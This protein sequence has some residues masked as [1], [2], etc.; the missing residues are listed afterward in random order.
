MG[1]SNQKNDNPGPIMDLSDHLD[2][3]RFRLILA[4][5][6]LVIAIIVCLF[7]GNTIIMLLQKP[8]FFVMGKESHLQSLSPAD[9]FI[10]YMNVSMITGIILASPWIFYQLWMFISVGLYLKEKYYVYITLPFAMLLFIAGSLFFIFI[11]APVTLRFL[12][13]FNRELLH[14]ESNFTFKNYL[15]FI[16]NMTLA[17]G[18]AF[19][20]PIVVF[21]LNKIGLISIEQLC[22]SRKVVLLG[23]V[24]IAAIITPG[25]DL[26]SLSSLAIPLYLLFEI[27]ILI[28][29]FANRKK[30]A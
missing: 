17:F 3:L 27:G 21:F 5:A 29:R 14:V 10:T 28:S 4:F 19:E 9:G 13:V 18:L 2:E 15:S 30:T 1:D 24:V 22:K 12:V 8:Y 20:T 25:S 6:G 16:A 11:I 7:F 23:V 26:F